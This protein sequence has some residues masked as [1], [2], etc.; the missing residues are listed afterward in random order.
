MPFHINFFKWERRREGL[1]KN[2]KD[3]N[4]L[5]KIEET[6][7]ETLILNSCNSRLIDEA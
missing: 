4:S 6:V 2:N 7:V 1:G 3:M 5:A